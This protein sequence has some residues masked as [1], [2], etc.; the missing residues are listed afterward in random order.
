MED[1]QTKLTTFV[2]I[3]FQQSIY[4]TVTKLNAC[5]FKMFAKNHPAIT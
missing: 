3:K 5:P 2:A 1:S 4:V